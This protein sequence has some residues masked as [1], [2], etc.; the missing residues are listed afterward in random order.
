M[1]SSLS[2]ILRSSSVPVLRQS[3]RRKRREE[4]RSRQRSRVSSAEARAG[5]VLFSHPLL[6][7]TNIYGTSTECQ[8]KHTHQEH[9][10]DLGSYVTGF[11]P[12]RGKAWQNE[13]GEKERSEKAGALDNLS[14]GHWYGAH[15]AGSAGRS[16]AAPGSPSA[17]LPHPCTRC[18]GC[19]SC[20]H[21]HRPA[22][23]G[24]P[25]VHP[26]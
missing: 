26:A 12:E 1:A 21:R 8:A 22:P 24:A 5:L 13:G 4:A 18:P 6:P 11:R 19:R 14:E 25:A 15:R 10:C 9:I 20:R 16:Y 17:A 2:W 23:R 3:A 7:P